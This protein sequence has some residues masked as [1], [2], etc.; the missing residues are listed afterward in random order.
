VA[1]KEAPKKETL[2][3]NMPKGK[4]TTVLKEPYYENGELKVKETI[5]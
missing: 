1:K 2:A 4:P 5:I 3:K